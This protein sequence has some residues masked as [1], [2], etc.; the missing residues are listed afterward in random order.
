LKNNVF[1]SS[2]KRDVLSTDSDTFSS[3]AE[4]VTG[5]ISLPVWGGSAGGGG[6]TA[7]A[8]EMGVSASGS[9]WF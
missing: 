4:V 2:L 7:G 6:E 1:I 3:S 8:K 9:T 5:S